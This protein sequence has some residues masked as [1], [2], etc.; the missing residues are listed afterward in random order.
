MNKTA[1][2]Y[3]SGK[4]RRDAGVFKPGRRIKVKTKPQRAMRG[5]IVIPPKNSTWSLCTHCKRNTWVDS[6]NLISHYN[7]NHPGTPLPLES[8]IATTNPS[9]SKQSVFEVPIS[10]SDLPPDIQR[11]SQIRSYLHKYHP[12]LHGHALSNC[13]RNLW[14]QL[15]PAVPLTTRKPLK[16]KLQPPAKKQ[17]KKVRG[18]RIWLVRAH[19]SYGSK[20]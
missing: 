18:K 7:F 14:R 3:Q 1:E 17:K 19:G 13:V 16:S 5:G 12:Y 15:P 9:I 20:Q 11:P 2:K 10:I 4:A 8:V 6:T